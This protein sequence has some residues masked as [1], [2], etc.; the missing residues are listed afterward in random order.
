VSL[1][2]SGL[3]INNKTTTANNTITNKFLIILFSGFLLIYTLGFISNDVFGDSISKYLS[4]LE[5]RS[6]DNNIKDYYQCSNKS[7]SDMS[8]CLRDYVSEVYNYSVQPDL[9]REI[10][11]IIKSGG[12]CHDYSIL[13]AKMATNLNYSYKLVDIYVENR[14]GH[15]FVILYD[16]TGYCKLDQLDMPNCFIY[17][18]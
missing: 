7:I 5:T 9:D 14:T 8:D 2:Y 18:D 10:D 12:D 3:V 16:K 6:E 13:Y 4:N 1:P 11:D 15:E 17:G